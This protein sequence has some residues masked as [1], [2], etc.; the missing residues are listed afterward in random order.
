MNRVPV[1]AGI[2]ATMAL[3]LA[4]C[5]SQSD[6]GPSS[7]PDPNV[8]TSNNA[9]LVLSKGGDAYV[10]GTLRNNSNDEV[11]IVGGTA[12]SAS[13]VTPEQVVT[14]DGKKTVELPPGGIPIPAQSELTLEPTNYRI[15]IAGLSPTPPKDGTINVNLAL[16]NG[17]LSRI[18]T[19]VQ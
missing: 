8:V 15:A 12:E 5:S 16:S 3:G 17:S 7:S 2:F 18:A 13:K 1:T 9:Q 11:K 6:S 4:A 10:Y 19:T 14:V